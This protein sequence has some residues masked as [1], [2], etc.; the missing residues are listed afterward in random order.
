MSEFKNYYF[1]AGRESTEL[2]D[3]MAALSKLKRVGDYE[4]KNSLFGYF[5]YS[6]GVCYALI[7]SQEIGWNSTLP[8]FNDEVRDNLTRQFLIDIIEN[9]EV[10][11]PDFVVSRPSDK[12][13]V[14]D[15]VLVV[16]SGTPLRRPIVVWASRIAQNFAV[17]ADSAGETRA[18]YLTDLHGF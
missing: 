10:G 12:I 18:I 8:N 6:Q 11:V 9:S 17:C 16:S 1:S 13:K 2:R 15:P 14:G 4:I 3:V 7:N 5:L